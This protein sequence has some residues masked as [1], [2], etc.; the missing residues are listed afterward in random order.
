MMVGQMEKHLLPQGPTPLGHAPEP[1]PVVD[2]RF[3][4]PAEQGLAGWV[5]EMSQRPSTWTW[6]LAFGPFVPSFDWGHINDPR[7]NRLAV[8]RPLAFSPGCLIY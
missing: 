8:Q 1:E 2:D 7:R 4:D 6:A 5:A 3:L